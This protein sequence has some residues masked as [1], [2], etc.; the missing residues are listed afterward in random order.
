MNSSTER[1]LMVLDSLGT[2]GTETYALSLAGPLRA[3]G[4]SL[5][6]T[7]ANGP[8]HRAFA[9][10][11]YQIHLPK[12][13]GRE[14]IAV[15]RRQAEKYYRSVMEREGITVVHVHQTPSGLPA[16]SAAKQLG[17]PVVFTLHGTYYPVEEAVQ[18]ARLCD[19]VISVS[20]PVQKYW[21]QRGI[22]SAVIANGVDVQLF[23]PES[24]KQAI[25]TE[26]RL[27][28]IAPGAPVVTYVSRL[29][30]QKASVCNML[31]RATKVLPGL[32]DLHVI[33]VGTGPQSHAVRELAKA[34]NRQRGREYI[35]FVGEKTDV[36]PYY[37]QS[38]LVVG[39]GR[40]AL[41]AM[42]TGKPVLAIGNHGFFGLVTPSAYD[43]AWDYYFGDHAS[44][45][46]PSSDLIAQALQRAFADREQLRRWGEQAREW[47]QEQ[48]DIEQV[49]GQILA[50][51][52]ACKQR[53]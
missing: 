15:R 36:R 43:Q 21:A 7:G 37:A 50:V 28:A 39:T 26:G 48:F 9:Q 49:S 34:L 42:A 41:E 31:L 10:A 13:G 2:G 11:G 30:W 27:P 14:P 53:S 3:R 44:I 22:A 38:D 32:S 19:A 46:K 45:A 5:F 12:T 25:A 4:V 1:V 33:V 40:V 17:I 20:K 23:H 51:Y 29:A 8:L 6:C 47:V 18:L 16:A 35:H 52:A 24:G